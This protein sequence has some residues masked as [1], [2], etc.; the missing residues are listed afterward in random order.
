MMSTILP[1][2]AWIWSMVCTTSWITAPPRAATPAVVSA[3]VL[4]WR[5]LSAFCFTVD[6]SSSIEDAVSSSE[7]ACCSVR[8]DRSWL[9]A[10]T[11]D[12]AV[13]MASVPL[14]TV[15]TVA[16]RFSFMVLRAPSSW[17]NSH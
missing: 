15:V 9:P 14:R 10:A 8:E 7:L 5:A 2:A 6:V 16:T 3:R 1:D 4:A 17:P 11:C 12:D 13:A